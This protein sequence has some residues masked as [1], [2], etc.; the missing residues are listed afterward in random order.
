M[1]KDLRP[2]VEDTCGE[3]SVRSRG[4]LDPAIVARLRREVA[5]GGTGPLYPMMWTLMIFELWCRAVLDGAGQ[6][7]LAGQ[8]AEAR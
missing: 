4:L 2:L 3:E 5:G 7:A 1:L 6:R 8:T